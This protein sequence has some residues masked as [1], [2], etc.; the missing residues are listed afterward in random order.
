MA[1]MFPSSRLGEEEEE[2]E[3]EEN[4]SAWVDNCEEEEAKATASLP[5]LR[6]PL[7]F[8]SRPLPETTDPSD[9]SCRI[10]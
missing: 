4:S 7:V 8:P 2:E 6:R 5:P 10:L 3:E 9:P 1:S